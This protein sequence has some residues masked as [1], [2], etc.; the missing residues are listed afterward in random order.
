M[1]DDVE[2][3]S[4]YRREEASVRNLVQ[5]WGRSNRSEWPSPSMPLL[6][7]GVETVIDFWSSLSK[8]APNILKPV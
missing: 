6:F 5:G 2:R 4:S 7:D 8:F 1:G 3:Q